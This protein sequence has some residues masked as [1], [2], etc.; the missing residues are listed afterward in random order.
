MPGGYRTQQ[1]FP[2]Y[3]VKLH[4]EDRA[5]WLVNN[6]G[7]GFQVYGEVFEVDAPTLQAMDVLEEVG[8]PSGY[9]RVEIALE[10]MNAPRGNTP[11]TSAYAYLKQAHQ[12]ADSLA[13]EGPFEAY[14]LELAKGYWFAA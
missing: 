14:T 2:L 9:L 12:M 6:P 10:A 11:T 13:V 7:E 5:P 3:V 4:N 8:Q 1:A